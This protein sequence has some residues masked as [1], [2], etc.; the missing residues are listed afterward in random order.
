M[1]HRVEPDF[2]LPSGQRRNVLFVALD[3]AVIGLMSAAASFVS[4]W[5]VRLGASPFWVSLLSSMPSTIALIMTMPWSAFVARQRHPQRVFAFARLA[6][7]TIYPLV[8]VVPF[9]LPQEWAARVIVLIWACSAFPSSLSNIMFTLVMG[10]AVPG[11][12]RAFLM[13]RRWMV[14]GLANLVALPIVSQVIDRITFP[15]GYQLVY[16]INGLLAVLA[17]YLAMQLRVAETEPAAPAARAPAPQRLRNAIEEVRAHRDFLVFVG[18]RGVLNLGLTLISAAVP[19]YWVQHLQATDAWV[20]YFNSAASAATLIA[21][22][23]WVRIK[24]RY[25]TRSTLLPAVLAAALYPALLAL[26]RTPA[27]VLPA[28]ALNGFAGAGINLAFF[29]AL[30]EAVPRGREARFVAINMTVVNLAGVIGPTLGAALVNGL[31]IRAVFVASTLIALGG[32][33]IFAFLSPRRRPGEA[34]VG[35]AVASE[36]V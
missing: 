19:I 36:Q 26:T 4:V 14:M 34:A 35:Q 1:T 8:A 30:L 28:I 10:N 32:V 6:V 18:G 15:H 16:G 25:G 11:E 7:H 33:A 2:P 23:P 20:G 3:G 24:R 31:P 12:K 27:A 9:F 21:Y 22:I 17:F 5:V 13:S 29:D